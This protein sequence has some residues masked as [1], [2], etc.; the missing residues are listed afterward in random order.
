MKAPAGTARASGKNLQL[1]S[2]IK[3]VLLPFSPYDSPGVLPKPLVLRANPEVEVEVG[4]G[5]PAEV[6]DDEDDLGG[7]HVAGSEVELHADACSGN[8][9]AFKV[10]GERGAA[11]RMEPPA[12]LSIAAPPKPAAAAEVRGMVRPMGGA[13]F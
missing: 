7:L 2:Q 13:A 1:T 11:V 12:S 9:L 4:D 8:A 5:R 10:E 6:E 3:A